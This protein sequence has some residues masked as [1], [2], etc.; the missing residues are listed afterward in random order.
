VIRGLIRA[1]RARFARRG[2]CRGLAVTRRTRFR[3]DFGGTR[4]GVPGGTGQARAIAPV[5]AQSALGRF[6]GA[7]VAVV[8]EIPRAFGFVTTLSGIGATRRA[9]IG[10]RRRWNGGQKRPQP[11]HSMHFLVFLRCG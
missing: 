9:S 2:L 6:I 8:R 10:A 11:Q 7:C 4:A 5:L 3:T 1:G